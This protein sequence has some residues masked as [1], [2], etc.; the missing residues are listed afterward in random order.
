MTQ[1]QNLDDP[2]NLGWI[3]ANPDDPV[4]N[5]KLYEEDCLRKLGG[6]KTWYHMAILAMWGKEFYSRSL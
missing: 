1:Q 4:A 2:A 6:K 5:F 3:H